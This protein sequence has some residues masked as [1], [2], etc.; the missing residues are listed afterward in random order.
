MTL[1]NEKFEELLARQ[2]T[3][4]LEP[5][6]GKAAAAFQTHVAAE[7]AERAAA[8][9][10]AQQVAGGSKD[11]AAWAR[12]EVS[13]RVLWLWTGVPSLIAAAL[14]VVVTLQFTGTGPTRPTEPGNPIV[15]SVPVAPHLGGGVSGV[16]NGTLAHQEEVTQNQA[17]DVVIQNNQPVRVIHQQQIRTTEWVDPA[18]HATY[19]LTEQPAEKVISVPVQPY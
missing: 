12:R 9:R 5:Q 2:L 16:G 6:R 7:A 15:N 8:Q 10:A 19:H 13:G 3:R 1:Q 14:A 11:H 17:G 18:D 4:E